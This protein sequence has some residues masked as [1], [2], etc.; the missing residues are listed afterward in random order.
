MQETQSWKK[1]ISLG[2]SILFFVLIFT[3]ASTVCS[4]SHILYTNTLTMK[5]KCTMP[6]TVN[7]SLDVCSYLL[8]NFNDYPSG[9]VTLFNLLVMGNWQIWMEVRISH[10][11][12]NC[13][14]LSFLTHLF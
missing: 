10:T 7:C 8:F 3:W 4:G 6:S 12:L 14:L 2:M 9:M 11:P 5:S 13:N 1:Q